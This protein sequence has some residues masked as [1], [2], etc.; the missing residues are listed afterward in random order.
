VI[1]EYIAKTLARGVLFSGDGRESMDGGPIPSL[2][3]VIK[4][5]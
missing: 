1:S 2:D 5:G 3:G 4:F